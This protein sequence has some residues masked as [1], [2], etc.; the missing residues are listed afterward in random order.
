MQL[1]RLTSFRNYVIS[2][3]WH[4]WH[5]ATYHLKIP[6]FSAAT[7]FSKAARLTHHMKRRHRT[8]QYDLEITTQSEK[9]W[10]WALQNSGGKI[11][12][13]EKA[14]TTGTSTVWR[15]GIGTAPP[16][17]GWCNWKNWHNTACR[18]GTKTDDLVCQDILFGRSS[19][20][21]FRLCL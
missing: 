6:A 1:D 18:A 3:T 13:P 17:R 15:A 2:R 7:R 4:A 5:S 21:S 14:S 20:Q 19:R 12:Q 10:K 16:R 8:Q 11:A 9:S